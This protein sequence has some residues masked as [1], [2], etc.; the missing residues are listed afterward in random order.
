MLIEKV[1]RRDLKTTPKDIVI[2]I[3]LII[4]VYSWWCLLHLIR[5]GV[6]AL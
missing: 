2:A 4:F 5:L 3:L 1:S 6:E